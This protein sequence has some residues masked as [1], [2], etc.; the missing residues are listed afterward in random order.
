MSVFSRTFGKPA[1]VHFSQY[2]KTS[3]SDDK[4]A[5]EAPEGDKPAEDV[6]TS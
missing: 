6:K 5:G 1:K 2:L 3:M 4:G